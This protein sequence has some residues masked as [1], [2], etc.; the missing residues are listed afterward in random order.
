MFGTRTQKLEQQKQK[1]YPLSQI[2]SCRELEKINYP[3]YNWFLVISGLKGT[4]FGGLDALPYF[5]F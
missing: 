2:N 4:H 3:L 1:R 5:I